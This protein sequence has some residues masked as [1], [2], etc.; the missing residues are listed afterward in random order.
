MLKSFCQPLCYS[1]PINMHPKKLPLF[2]YTN[3]WLIILSHFFVGRAL[4]VFS[5]RGRITARKINSSPS[6]N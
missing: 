3:I 2:S 6:G 4:F 5:H 1:F